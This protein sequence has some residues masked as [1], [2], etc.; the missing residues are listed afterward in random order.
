MAFGAVSAENTH[1][2]RS[3]SVTF[4]QSNI[5]PSTAMQI[6][7]KATNWRQADCMYFGMRSQLCKAPNAG[8]S[9]KLRR[10]LHIDGKSSFILHITY[11][12]FSQ[13]LIHHGR[14]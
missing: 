8:T 7:K 14:S 2:T 9:R 13:C 6:E 3:H 5:Y 10:Y 12:E 1:S 11:I 4:Q